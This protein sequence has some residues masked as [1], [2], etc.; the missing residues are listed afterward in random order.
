MA[1]SKVEF[2]SFYWVA[3]DGKIEP[4]DSSSILANINH[5]ITLL[6]NRGFEPFATVS[7]PTKGPDGKVYEEGGVMILG[8]YKGVQLV[9]D[10]GSR[11]RIVI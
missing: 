10:I 1:K 7:I 5:R 11:T 3:E 9:E 8:K 2:V 4:Q 6:E